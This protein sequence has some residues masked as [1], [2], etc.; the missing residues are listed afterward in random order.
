MPAGPVLSG[1][2]REKIKNRLQ[3]L[4]TS[5]W[6]TKGYKKTSIK[7]LCGDAGISVGT[8]YTLYPAKEDLFF[9][10]VDTIQRSLEEQV[11]TIVRNA[12]TMDGFASAIKTLAREFDKMPFLYDAN[13]P[14]FLSFI[15]KLSEETMEKLKSDRIDFLRKFIRAANLEL[16]VSERKAHGAL[17]ALLATIYAKETIS[18]AYDYFMVFDF[19][20]DGLIPNIFKER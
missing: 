12:P 13:T 8:F 5:H 16:L 17:N 14:D 19:M 11:F 10:T 9:A 4:C 20:V 6:I 18:V 7:E 3:E 1:I 15:T 2:E